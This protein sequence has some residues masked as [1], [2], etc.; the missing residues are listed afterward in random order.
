MLSTL[1]LVCC[2]LGC[3]ALARGLGKAPFPTSLLDLVLMGVAVFHVLPEVIRL[4]DD[5]PLG[6]YREGLPPTAMGAWLL[7]TSVSM[8]SFGAGAALVRTRPAQALAD[9]PLVSR[10]MSTPESIFTLTLTAVAI[11]FAAVV[12]MG[13]GY[14]GYDSDN[15]LLGSTVSTTGVPVLISVAVLATLRWRFALIVV[16]AIAGVLLLMGSRSLVGWSLLTGVVLVRRCG[17]NIRTARLAVAITVCASIIVA[18]ALIRDRAGRWS[19][20]ATLQ[21][22][23]STVSEA[24]STQVGAGN[25]SDLI[26]DS[27]VHRIDGNGYGARILHAQS[28]AGASL[29]GT[30]ALMNS[31]LLAIPSLVWTSKLDTP[32]E[33]RN[34][35]GASV[36]HY[37]IEV[38]DYLPTV[39]GSA[40]SMFGWPGAI[41]VAGVFGV[42]VSALDRLLPTRRPHHLP[43]A[44][45]MCLVALNFEGSVET[46]I[47]GCR[48]VATVALLNYS[49]WWLARAISAVLGAGAAADFGAHS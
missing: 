3:I 4:A 8:L 42:A 10:S 49:A 39:I 29:M 43:I 24:S 7:V 44:A 6:P 19:Q 25:T 40:T 1:A 20:D 46:V 13:M 37:G 27:F 38:T 16:V 26:L 28:Q 32:V 2:F 48:T 11:V 34:Q 30:E 5:V 14:G 35:E 15:Y 22:R 21:D 9:L 17:G 12:V 31:V 36:V 45:A 41:V 33:Q 18:I 47:L 23:M